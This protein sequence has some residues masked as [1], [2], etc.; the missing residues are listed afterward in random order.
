MHQAGGKR[1]HR[2][3]DARLFGRSPMFRHD[4]TDKWCVGQSTGS[5][6]RQIRK[7]VALLDD[8]EAALAPVA[9]VDRTHF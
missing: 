6:K 3:G 7:S 8:V 9:V 2:G 1:P 4:N 5:E